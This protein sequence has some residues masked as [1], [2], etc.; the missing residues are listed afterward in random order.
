MN[1][2]IRQLEILVAAADAGSFSKAAAALSI[3]QPALSEAIR[4]IEG[5]LGFRVFERTTR[6]VTLTADGRQAV[7][8]ARDVVRNFKDAM[9]DLAARQGGRARMVIAALPSVACAVLPLALR[10]FGASHP[11]AE[12]IIHDVQHERVLALL[13]DGVADL[14]VT[15]RPARL[16]GLSFEDAAADAMHLVCRRDHPLAAR[17]RVRWRDLGDHPFVGM[18]GISSVR[19]LTD[20]ALITAAPT[21]VTRYEVEQIPSAIALVEAGLGITALPALTFSMFQGRQLVMRPLID[22]PMQRRI[23]FVRRRDRKPSPASQDLADAL[24][25]HLVKRLRSVR[26]G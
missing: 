2:T 7:A 26:A 15:F 3:T 10:D 14:A 11:D 5:E 1:V 12:V 21:S 18:T 23:G 4:R 6:S 20:A 25:I 9:S 19:R 17:K 24:R 8:T 22:P 13:A 16:D